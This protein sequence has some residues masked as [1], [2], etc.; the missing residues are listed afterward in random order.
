MPSNPPRKKPNPT[1]APAEIFAKLRNKILKL[2]PIEVGVLQTRETP[3][4]WGV[5]METGYPEAVVT[6]VSLADG[7][8]SLYFSSGGGMIGGG[9]HIP[10]AR[11]AKAFVATAEKYLQQMDLTRVFP[12]PTVGRV[13]F[14]VLTFSGVLTLDA[15]ENELGDGKH[16]LSPLFYSG[17]DVIAQFRAIEEQ[18]K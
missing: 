18:K 3:N 9:K 2:D 11:S 15:D 5:L 17:Q 8:A 4:V 10:L 1:A 12:L 6:L 7:T 16:V 14:Y 13:R